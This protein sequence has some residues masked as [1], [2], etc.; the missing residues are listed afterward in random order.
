MS[1]DT[2]EFAPCPRCHY[3]LPRSN[4]AV[5]PECGCEPILRLVDPKEADRTAQ[6]AI[7]AAVLL[8]ATSS[9]IPWFLLTGKPAWRFSIGPGL[10][11]VLYSAICMAYGIGVLGVFGL[12]RFRRRVRNLDWYFW[13][14]TTVAASMIPVLATMVILILLVD[15]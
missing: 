8:L 14:T 3:P 9:L 2:P 6:A 10:W 12:P 5:C 1:A 13:S 4:L 7:P 11:A 15:R